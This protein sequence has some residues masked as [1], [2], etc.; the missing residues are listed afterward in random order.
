LP[1]FEAA[2]CGNPVITPA[3]GGQADFLNEENS[4]PLKYNLTPVG[5][6]TWSP[7]YRGDQ[8]WAEPDL[9][10]AVNTMRHVY[11]NREEAALKGQLAKQK[12]AENFTWDKIGDMIVNR[13]AQLDQGGSNA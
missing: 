1:H 10:H 2:A 12:V 9:E 4:Y 6:M 3:Y 13:L 5:G 7:Y 11:N 8:Y